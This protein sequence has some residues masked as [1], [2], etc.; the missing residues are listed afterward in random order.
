MASRVVDKGVFVTIAAGNDGESGG[1]LLYTLHPKVSSSPLG[2]FW[3]TDG[4]A[5]KVSIPCP[6]KG[7]NS[8]T[9]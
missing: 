2:P 9:V 6:K 3:F 1:S 7:R 4:G 5:A 8:S